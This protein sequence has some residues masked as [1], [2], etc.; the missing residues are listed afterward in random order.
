MN[1]IQFALFVLLQESFREDAMPDP[2]ESTERLE[3][4]ILRRFQ[5]IYQDINITTENNTLKIQLDNFSSN[6]AEDLVEIQSKVY[7]DF[8][9]ELDAESLARARAI[10]SRET[11][12][13]SEK[14]EIVNTFSRPLKAFDEVNAVPHCRTGPVCRDCHTVSAIMELMR[15][16]P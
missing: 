6:T 15:E 11:I 12:S 10:L 9:V 8:T 1:K 2:T 4:Y 14:Q 13:S 16:L 3:E 5:K 7:V